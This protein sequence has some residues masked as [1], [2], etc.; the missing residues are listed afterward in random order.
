M[1][2]III[3]SALLFTISFVFVSSAQAATLYK[4]DNFEAG[5]NWVDSYTWAYPLNAANWDIVTKAPH[6]GSYCAQ[7]KTPNVTIEVSKGQADFDAN[8]PTGENEI[9]VRFWFKASPN[10]SCDWAQFLRFQGHYAGDTS[11]RDVEIGSAGYNKGD[12]SVGEVCGPIIVTQASSNVFSGISQQDSGLGNPFVE[13]GWTEYAFYTNYSQNKLYFWKNASAYTTADPGFHAMSGVNYGTW[14][15]FKLRLP[16][17]Y[18]SYHTETAG[19]SE[20]FWMDDIEIWTGGIPGT[21]TPPPP[22]CTNFTYSTFGTCQSDGTQSRT[23]TSSIPT[24]CVGGSPVLTQACT[25]SQTGDTTPPDL[26]SRSPV[27]DAANVSH[28][29]R[30]ISMRIGDGTAFGA[31][32]STIKLNVN[33][34][35]Y[36]CQTGSCANKT[37][38]CTGTPGNYLVTYTHSNDWS[39]GQKVNLTADASDSAI[40]PNAMTQ[41]A[42]SFTV[43]NYA[44]ATTYNLTNFTQLVSDWLKT[45]SSSP[46]DINSDGKVNSQDLGIMMSNWK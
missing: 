19:Q 11:V 28:T 44:T 18:K 33:G 37:L 4:S 41:R 29:N 7:S 3:F 35:D 39:S 5:P 34:Q 1:T 13:T 22:T 23:I 26:W 30:N 24:G 12:N 16:I 2:K 43:E 14:R 45:I 46:A 31:D 9:F 17:Y 21:T 42:W 8:I 15:M 36:C 27:P 20:L 38:F 6:S 32:A 25:S 40:P 10:L